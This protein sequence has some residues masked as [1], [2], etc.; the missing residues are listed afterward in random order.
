MDKELLEKYF[1]G[2]QCTEEELRSIEDYLEGA[3]PVD[4]FFYDQWKNAQGKVNQEESDRIWANISGRIPAAN[5]SRHLVRRPW[6]AVAAAMLGV[7][8]LSGGLMYHIHRQAKVE[9][10]W[11]EVRNSSKDVKYIRLEDGTQVWLNANSSLSYD[12]QYAHN[13][14]REIRLEGEAFFDVTPD[15]LQPLTV[16]T[17]QLR[18]TVLGTSFDIRAWPSQD[19]T[20]VALVSGKVQVSAVVSGGLSDTI[21]TNAAAMDSM[22]LSPGELL[23]YDGLTK[24]CAIAQKAVYGDMTEWIK[25]KIVLDNTLLPDILQQL[26]Q[27][28]KVSI[29]LDSGEAVKLRLSGQFRRGGIE[30]MLKNV[31][32]PLDLTYSYDNGKYV[33]HN[34]KHH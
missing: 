16:H 14:R 23:N 10:V 30:D 3:G 29:S 26:E 20:Q 32:F 1:S 24:R 6:V 15:P 12:E 17:R 22:I 19:R 13:G 28:Y 11:K 9:L 7:V 4:A 31:L 25:G 18:T 33:V 21:G 34:M 5:I 8:L 2:V 27:L